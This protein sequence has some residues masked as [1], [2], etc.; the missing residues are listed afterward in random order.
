MF[1]SFEVLLKEI[2]VLDPYQDKNMTLLKLVESSNFTCSSRPGKNLV[3][4]L[5]KYA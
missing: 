2:F 1:V 4:N 3:S 5:G